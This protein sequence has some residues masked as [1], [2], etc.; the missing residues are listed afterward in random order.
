MSII[1]TLL[2]VCIGVRETVSR[3]HSRCRVKNVYVKNIPVKNTL[4]P[5]IYTSPPCVFAHTAGGDIPA[6]SKT[7]T[8]QAR[9]WKVEFS[10]NGRQPPQKK[11]NY[12]LLSGQPFCHS[13]AVWHL[14][15]KWQNRSYQ[16]NNGVF[17]E[18]GS[19]T[20][21]HNGPRQARHNVALHWTEAFK[22]LK[23]HN[24]TIKVNAL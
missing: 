19:I 22:L 10:G 24:S 6:A 4:H 5:W 20:V 8:V 17:V 1:E 21:G 12:F 13:L 9:Y 23:G 7:F 16:T 18:A 14:Q 2:N 3:W 15:T 11:L